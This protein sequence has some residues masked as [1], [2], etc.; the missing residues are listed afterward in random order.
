MHFLNYKLWGLNNRNFL[1][2]IVEVSGFTKW[3]NSEIFLVKDKYFT[4]FNSSIHLILKY[5][6]IKIDTQTKGRNI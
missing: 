6:I 1:H 3:R 5:L 2:N 4:D